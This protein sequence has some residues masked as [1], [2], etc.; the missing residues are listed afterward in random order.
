MTEPKRLEEA[1]PGCRLKKEI[2]T[3]IEEV[4][5]AICCW[6]CKKRGRHLH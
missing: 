1:Q 4:Q 3:G 6:N 2:G 5:Q